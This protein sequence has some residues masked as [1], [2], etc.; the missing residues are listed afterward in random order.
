MEA[1]SMHLCFQQR[2]VL[3]MPQR[4]KMR[5]DGTIT[6]SDDEA[7][8]GKQYRKNTQIQSVVSDPQND[9]RR[10]SQDNSCVRAGI[11]GTFV[12]N[13]LIHGKGGRLAQIQN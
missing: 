12:N 13:T 10:L 2:M 7:R 6:C 11:S 4:N 3:A 5:L 9:G 8:S 1:L